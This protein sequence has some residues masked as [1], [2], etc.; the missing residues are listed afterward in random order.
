MNWTGW[1]EHRSNKM[2]EG[3]E[4]GRQSKVEGGRVNISEGKDDE[5]FMRR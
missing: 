2:Q 5:S 3:K 1:V 4:S